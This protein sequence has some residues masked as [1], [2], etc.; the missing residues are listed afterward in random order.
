MA[1]R[2]TS[3]SPDP[4]PELISQPKHRGTCSLMVLSSEKDLAENDII[5]R[6]SLKEKAQRFEI[7]RPTRSTIVSN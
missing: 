3:P 1:G 6:L 5:R 2:L 7:S 4:S